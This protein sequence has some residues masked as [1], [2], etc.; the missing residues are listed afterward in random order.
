MHCATLH[1]YYFIVFIST[2]WKIFFSCRVNKKYIIGK[3]MKSWVWTCSFSK[4]VSSASIAVFFRSLLSH[5]PYIYIFLSF[6]LCI[7]TYMQSFSSRKR[8]CT[9]E[10]CWISSFRSRL[11]LLMRNNLTRLCFKWIRMIRRKRKLSSLALS[12]IQLHEYAKDF[13]CLHLMI[14]FERQSLIFI[15]F[16]LKPFDLLH[17]NICEAF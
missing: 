13:I 17:K 9:K 12:L 3:S 1:E 10:K 6:S 2:E 11:I 7:S 4:Q 8:Y 16:R 5:R 14:S 15:Y